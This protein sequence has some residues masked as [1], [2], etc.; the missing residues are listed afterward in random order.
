M[1]FVTIVYKIYLLAFFTYFYIPI[2]MF[3]FHFQGNSAFLHSSKFPPPGAIAAFNAF[4][5]VS[6]FAPLI[7]ESYF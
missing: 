5:D 4:H 3:M 7:V 6:K 2:L 1:G